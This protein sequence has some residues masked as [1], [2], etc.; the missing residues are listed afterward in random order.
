MRCLT[1]ANAFAKQGCD[2]VFC[3]RAWDGNLY[4]KV[5]A[6]GIAVQQFSG[7]SAEE[8]RIQKD[9]SQGSQG[10]S[11][12]LVD[13]R[14]T[15]QL[16]KENAVTMVVVDH[17][18]LDAKWESYLRERGI[19]VFVID[20]LANRPHDCDYLLDQTLLRPKDDYVPYVPSDCTLFLGADYCL[21]RPDF[22]HHR[23]DS[24]ARRANSPLRSILISMGGGDP[25]QLSYHALEALVEAVL[26]HE[27]A[28]SVI[29]GPL[30]DT[31]D[32]LDKLA[33]RAP[34]QVHI[35]HNVSHMAQIM[36]T[37]DIIINSGGT[38]NWE[39][40][41][42]G[43]PSIVTKV[44]S[45]QSDIIS[46]LVSQDLAFEVAHDSVTRFQKDVVEVIT[47][48]QNQ[49]DRFAEACQKSAQIVDAHGTERVMKA[50]L[51]R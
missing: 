5:E 48:L 9:F 10:F 19:A 6:A 13:A 18:L 2:S 24:L 29:I 20:D 22:L 49:P 28:V 41:A 4:H 37:H 14:H 25:N 46:V 43:L 42:L 3:M 27:I 34:F 47:L 26:P 21:L 40:L 23:T 36:A 8:A 31:K 1:L 45:N 39:R 11:D 12:W 38:T 44:A 7:D 51:D 30:A 35:L 32:K 33:E 17:Y 50:V 15:Y 16:C